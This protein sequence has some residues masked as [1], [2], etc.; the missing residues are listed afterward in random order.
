M[1]DE[2]VVYVRNI[3][4][5][6]ADIIKGKIL[7]MNK[8]WLY[9]TLLDYWDQQPML[10]TLFHPHWRMDGQTHSTMEP[11]FV[12]KALNWSEAPTLIKRVVSLTKIYSNTAVII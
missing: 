11:K 9:Q 4:Q 5:N 1:Y 2:G 10:V 7:L 3:E 8:Y 12:K 6:T